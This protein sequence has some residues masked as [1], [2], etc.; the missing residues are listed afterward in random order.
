M[1]YTI[2]THGDPVLRQKSEQVTEI[3]E[4]VRTLLDDMVETMYEKGGVGLAANQIGIALRLVTIDTA[5]SD[6]SKIYKLVN[7]EIVKISKEKKDFEEGCLSFPGITENIERPA[8]I[9]VRAQ[10]EFGEEITINANG[11]LAVALQHEIDHI[12]GVTFVQRMTPVKRLVHK[13]ELKEL[14][15]KTVSK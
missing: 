11:L 9:T 4:K 13:N 10:D 2:R 8:E 5:D 6:D 1:I 14:K 7:P 3:N 12:N 15:K